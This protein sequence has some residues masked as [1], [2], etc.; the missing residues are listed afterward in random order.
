VKVIIAGCRNIT[1]VDADPLVSEAVHE[2]GWL[3]EITEVVSGAAKGIDQ[4]GE[5]W[6]AYMGIPCK[7]F[8]AAWSAYGPR[9]G[10]MR[11]RQMAGYADALIAVWDGLS[12]GTADMIGQARA[13]GLRVYVKRV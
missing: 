3:A 6:A 13:R 11:N 5:R 2:S 12:P 7:R 8:P 9:A 10:P 1:G 4:A